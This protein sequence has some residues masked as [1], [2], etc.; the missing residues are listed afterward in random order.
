M[1]CTE[2]KDEWVAW[3]YGELD[4]AAEGVVREH[5][6]SC[7]TCRESMRQLESSRQMLRESA[8]PVPVAP[9]VVVL[10]PKRFRRP[11]WAFAG[12]FLAAAA[13]FA[14][15][16]VTSPVLL[17]PPSDPGASAALEARLA[18]VERQ[19]TELA[20]AQ[21]SWVQTASTGVTQQ[22]LDASIDQALHRI[23]VGRARDFDFLLGEITAVE[24]RT[25][26]DMRSR[27]AILQ[28]ML[29]SNPGYAEH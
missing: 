28:T 10:E 4:P 2:W 5:L 14:F 3:I 17:G 26:R 9:R 23:E 12:G 1:S 11:T 19:S 22:E 25:G 20:T 21:Q 29:T 18:R 24:F 15:G 6:E 27:D 13:L 7:S 16:L 8:S